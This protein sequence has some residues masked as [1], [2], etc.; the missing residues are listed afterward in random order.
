MQALEVAD[1]TIWYSNEKYQLIYDIII[2]FVLYVN[3]KGGNSECFTAWHYRQPYGRKEQ[4]L[5]SNA[6]A[7]TTAVTESVAG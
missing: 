2:E 4:V 3:E 6:W 7:T 1:M 5:R